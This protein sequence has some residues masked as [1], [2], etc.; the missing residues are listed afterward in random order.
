MVWYMRS[1]LPLGAVLVALTTG[2][3]MSLPDTVPYP[4]SLTA[5]D[6][7]PGMSLCTRTAIAARSLSSAQA[8]GGWTLGAMGVAATG[9]GTFATLVND[10][11]GRLIAAAGLT[12]GGVAMG[13]V[14]YNLFL[15]SAASARLAETAD[16]AL[17]DKNDRHAWET[18]VRAK[19]AWGASKTDPDGITRELA[20]QTER[21]NRKLREEI[22]QLKKQTQEQGRPPQAA[23]V[24]AEPNPFGTRR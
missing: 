5:A 6:P 14:A 22:E 18:C 23:P 3:A 13:I 19:S 21:E 4:A 12:L 15:R 17:I 11:Q 9:A 10:Q 2:C 16:L 7:A 20:A 8:A 24:P 1:S